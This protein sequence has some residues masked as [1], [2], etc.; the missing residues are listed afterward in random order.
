MPFLSL[1]FACFHDTDPPGATIVNSDSRKDSVFSQQN[2]AILCPR[3]TLAAPQNVQPV[4]VPP[5]PPFVFPVGRDSTETQ[6]KT[7]GLSNRG[8]FANPDTSNLANCNG[9]VGPVNTRLIDRNQFDHDYARKQQ[10][11]EEGLLSKSGHEPRMLSEQDQKDTKRNKTVKSKAQ[12]HVGRLRAAGLLPPIGV[13]GAKTRLDTPNVADDGYG[14]KASPTRNS[15][16]HGTS[17]S[18]ARRYA[19]GK[20]AALDNINQNLFKQGLLSSKSAL[21][22]ASD[23]SAVTDTPLIINP[24]STASKAARNKAKDKD[25]SE[26]TVQQLRNVGILAPKKNTIAT[27]LR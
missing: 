2:N 23:Y 7:N 1:L 5:L 11:R 14:N 20:Q 16:G 15:V 21:N 22:I 18:T 24:D 19:A 13:Y 8:P 27:G 6:V 25:T 17:A 4:N 26:K 3:P 10:F 9:D 12:E